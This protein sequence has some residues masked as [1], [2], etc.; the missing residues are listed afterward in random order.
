MSSPVFNKV[1]GLGGIGTGLL[2]HSD[3][4][5]TLG[6]NESR[7]VTLSDAKDYCKQHIVLH[8]IASLCKDTCVLPI[9][10]VGN[11]SFGRQLLLDM[12]RVGMDTKY[13]ATSDR[14]STMLSICLQYKNKDGCN[15]SAL[16]SAMSIVTPQYVTDCLSLEYID[17]K[18]VAVALPEVSIESRVAF[19]SAAKSKGAYCVVSVAEGEAKEFLQT[20]AFN[21]CDLVAVNRAEAIAVAGLTDKPDLLTTTKDIALSLHEILSKKNANVNTLVTEGKHGGY[22]VTSK[23]IS[24]IAAVDAPVV[25]TT[26]AGDACLG[27]TVAGLVLGYEFQKEDQQGDNYN[28]KDPSATAVHVGM[29]CSGLAIQVKDS[30]VSDIDV[31]KLFNMR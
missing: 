20:G 11:D 24:H 8:Y 2:F 31:N 26:G 22:T 14:F 15:F 29:A 17:S 7:A 18:T 6:R 27:G 1:L 4:D 13:V 16:N 21:L 25:N 23:A 5:T 28:L 12:Q 3:I 9:G 10:A 19:L 30:L